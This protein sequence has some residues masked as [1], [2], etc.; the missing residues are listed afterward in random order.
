MIVVKTAAEIEKM[1]RI[2]GSCLKHRLVEES[3]VPGITTEELD[4]K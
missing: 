1:R 4:E 2:G 3:I